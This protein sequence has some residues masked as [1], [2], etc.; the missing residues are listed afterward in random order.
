MQ[1][2]ANLVSDFRV[3]PA[4][5]KTCHHNLIFEKINFNIPLPLPFYRD[6]QDCNSANVEMIQ[7]AIIYFNWKP[8]FSNNSINNSITLSFCKTLK[9]IFSNYIP[10][11]R[12]K[13]SYRKQK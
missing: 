8:T 7:K 9:N 5:Y 10:N 6:I 13:I 2:W 3:Y 4:L 1:T 11:R 12:M